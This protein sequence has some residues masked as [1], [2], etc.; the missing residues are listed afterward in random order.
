[1]LD[2]NA[3]YNHDPHGSLPYCQALLSHTPGYHSEGFF[4]HLYA[5]GHQLIESPPVRGRLVSSSLLPGWSLGAS[6]RTPWS[7][8]T[9]RSS[10]E[11]QSSLVRPLNS[12]SHARSSSALAR[13]S[14]SGHRNSK[15][16]LSPTWEESR[17]RPSKKKRRVAAS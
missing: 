16:A 17:S 12:G 13:D 11:H 1:M 7:L 3:C 6:S 5:H 9:P 2:H 15:R 8:S 14:S 4:G 10:R